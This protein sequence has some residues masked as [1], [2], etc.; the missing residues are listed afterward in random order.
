[1]FEN[2]ILKY[3]EKSNKILVDKDGSIVWIY[4]STK[5]KSSWEKA[6]RL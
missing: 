1:M 6:V 4:A 2:I 5:A 3:L